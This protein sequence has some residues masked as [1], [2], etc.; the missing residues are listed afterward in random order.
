M[1]RPSRGWTGGVRSPASGLETEGAVAE[2]G[3]VLPRAAGGGW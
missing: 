3:A 1:A 2:A